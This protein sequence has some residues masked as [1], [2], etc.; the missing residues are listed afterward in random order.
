MAYYWFKSFHLVGVVCW[1]AGLF[2]VGRLFVNHVEALA[3]PEP[4]RGVLH[5]Q[6]TGMTRRCYRGIC[7][8]ALVLTVGCAVGMLAVQPALLA[9]GWLLAKLGIVASLV[10]YH[11][12][13][14]RLMRQLAT[15]EHAY[16][17]TAFRLL[18]EVPTLVLVAVTVL[19]VFKQ[20]VTPAV[21]VQALGGLLTV[22]VLG[23]A[24]Y[25]RKRAR[26]AA[27]TVPAAALAA[28]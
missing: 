19:A 22:L 9:Q 25:R 8:P 21:L 20:L 26:D 12:W 28:R 11:L 1:M 10:A 4:A 24:G 15:G 7:G 3:R 5:E 14:G 17:S 23:F 27:Q 2:Y 16:G 6:L 13:C 18:N